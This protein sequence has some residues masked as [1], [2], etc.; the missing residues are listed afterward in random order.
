MTSKPKSENSRAVELL[1]RLIDARESEIGCDACSEQ[2][3]RLAELM[4]N[5]A[6]LDDALHVVRNHVSCCRG[7]QAE[8]DAL[9]A[10][11]KME[12]PPERFDFGGTRR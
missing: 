11:L 7:C 9:I 10:I 1:R 6:E 4:L 5:G 3:D 12:S 2:M 8:F